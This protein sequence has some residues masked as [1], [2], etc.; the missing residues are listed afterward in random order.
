MAGRGSLFLINRSDSNNDNNND[1]T[2]TPADEQ[3]QL[4]PEV[5]K[6][7]CKR[8]SWSEVRSSNATEVWPEKPLSRRNKRTF[9]EERDESMRHRKKMAVSL[10]NIDSRCQLGEKRNEIACRGT[11]LPACGRRNRENG[12]KKK[13]KRGR[14]S[15]GIKGWVTAGGDK[16]CQILL[17]R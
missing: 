2:Q 1:D 11:W 17:E 3:L 14:D 12:Q 15:I 7:S 4:E 10:T 16:R 8:Y 13:K 6:P 5:S 9:T